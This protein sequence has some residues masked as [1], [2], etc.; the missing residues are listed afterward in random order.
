MG[1]SATN[2]EGPREHRGEEISYQDSGP[3]TLVICGD[4][5]I[6]RVLVLLLRGSG[7]E[8]R[9][10][11]ASSLNEPGALENV[12]LL[13]LAPT[14]ELSTK[15]REAILGSLRDIPGAAEMAVLELVTPS[16][17]KRESMSRDAS[18]HLGPWPCSIE[19]LE[20]WIEAALLANPLSRFR[21]RAVTT[22]C[23][24]TAMTSCV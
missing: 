13:V 15:H 20:R 6:G 23:K 12:R 11:P 14:P 22:I 18:W 19:E 5:I 17:E 4:P 24:P 1:G 3:V 21:S 2:H 8:A 9:F 10:L 16:E 7:Y